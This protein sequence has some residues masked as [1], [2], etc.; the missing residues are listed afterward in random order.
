MAFND[1]IRSL[2]SGVS[3]F[4]FAPSESPSQG[5]V[6]P[7]YNAGWDYIGN[8]GLGMLASGSRNPLQAFGRAALGAT[9]MARNNSKESYTAQ[10]LK[11]EADA[12]KQERDQAAQ[13]H[14]MRE[15]YISKLP[16]D[17]Q[18]KA[19]SIP[20]YLEKLV[21]ATDPAFKDHEQKLYTVGGSLVDGNG[22]VV[23]QG[24]GGGVGDLPKGYRWKQD[25]SGAEPIPGVRVSGTPKPYVPGPGDRTAIRNLS[26]DNVALKQTLANLDEAAGLVKDANSGFLA[27]PRA[28][29]AENLPDG[30]V[31]DRVFGSPKQGAN[32]MRLKQIMDAEA[33][34]SMTKLLKGPTSD[35][36]VQIML[37]TVNDPNASPQR[38]QASINRVRSLIQA[39]VDENQTLISGTQD[40]SLY[41]PQGG[42]DGGDVPDGV[43]PEEWSVMTPEERAVWE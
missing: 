7:A 18:M 33:L 15:T 29:I 38:K 4:G 39:Q 22:H 16:P 10:R 2:G 9:E 28:Q 40:G 17:Q 6:D 25:G 31:P 36:D 20:G 1:F 30:M 35:K 37:T 34:A 5:P 43:T 23:Y 26:A 3:P 21:G 27:T 24:Q 14:Q 32:T 13:E 42:G 19:R 8:I 41:G 12:K 11:E